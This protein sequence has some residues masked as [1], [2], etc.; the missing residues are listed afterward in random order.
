MKKTLSLIAL[1]ALC[2][3]LMAAC[4]N[5]NKKTQN[6]E[7]SQEEIQVQKQALADTVLSQ[8]DAIAEQMFDASKKGFKIK[9]MELTPEEKAIK[10][11]YLLDL[12]AANSMVTKSQKVNA[13]AI[14]VIDYSVRRIYDMPLEEAKQTI[15]KLAAEVSNSFDADKYLNETTLSEKLRVVYE[16]CKKNGELVFFWQYCYATSMETGYVIANNPELFFSKITDEQWH[17]FEAVYLSL[18]KAA[19]ELAKYDDEMAQVVD[20]ILKNRIIVTDDKR[21][22]V[23]NSVESAKQFRI[24]NKDKYIARRNALL[25]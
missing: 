2:C 18:K 13:L 14:Y 22:Q 16:N 15:I 24:A 3:T 23:N 10:P 5:N 12:S 7:P 11:D 4:Q 1:A 9:E 21:V 20:F 19:M 25:Q 8:I 17:N 6:Q